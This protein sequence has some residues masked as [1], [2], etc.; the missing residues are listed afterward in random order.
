M[1]TFAE[2][3][4]ND[5]NLNIPRYIDS[6]DPEDIQDL[7]AHLNGGIP[8]RDIEALSRYW[9]EFPTLRRT[10]FT[11]GDRP[12]YGQARVPA[13]EV[14]AT[15]LEHPEFAAFEER[16]LSVFEGWRATH[17]GVLRGLDR[18]SDPKS[19]I[20]HISED[21]LARFSG[22]EL[23]SHYEVYQHLMDYWQRRCKT[24]CTPSPK[25]VGRLDA[26]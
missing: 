11:E 6:S 14:R 24:T 12:G 15:V 21:L 17:G 18:G 8:E 26:S 1:V 23:V 9:D 3:E 16:V 5:F 20:G 4:K 13:P 19:L 2:I 22:E 10:L 7:G 25:T